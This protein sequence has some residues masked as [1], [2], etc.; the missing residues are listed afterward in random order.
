[1]AMSPEFRN[2]VIAAIGGGSL[3]ISAAMIT[4]PNGDDG[5]EGIRLEPYLDVVGVPTVCY[6]HTGSDIVMGKTYTERQCKDLLNADLQS[7]ARQVDPVINADI[8]ETMRAALYSF[9]YNV[10]V[11][12]FKKSTMLR[13]INKGDNAAACNEMKRWVMA[14]GKKWKGLVNRREIEREVCMWGQK[15][16]K[17]DD[18]VGPL[19]PGVPPSAP[20]VF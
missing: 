2:K 5:L 3:A 20:G 13:L 15:P 4:G 12:A 11:G 18:G 19:N 9:A 17:T 6:G 14:G 8:P 7:V 10:G 1:M 16:Q